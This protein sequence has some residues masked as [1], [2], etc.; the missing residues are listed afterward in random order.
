[1]PNN[2]LHPANYE[3]DE[4]LYSDDGVDLTL[5]RWMLSLTP[6]QR[7]EVLIK[8]VQAV[9]CLREAVKK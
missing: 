8:N 4:S 3:S 9:N 6:E 2:K 1:M 5:I 7:L